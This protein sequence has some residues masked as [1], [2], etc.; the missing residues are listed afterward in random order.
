MKRFNEIKIC[1]YFNENKKLKKGKRT[2][3]P[4]IYWEKNTEEKN[5]KYSM[6]EKYVNNKD[7]KIQNQKFF[8]K[9]EKSR[10][11]IIEYRMRLKYYFTT[12]C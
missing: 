2:K 11:K 7:E 4:V 8:E 3:Y 1:S 5:S 10:E 6:R 9:N 12:I